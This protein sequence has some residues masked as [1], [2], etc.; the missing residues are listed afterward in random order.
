MILAAI[1]VVMSFIGTYGSAIVAVAS[2]AAA[3]LLRDSGGGPGGADQFQEGPRLGELGVTTSSYGKDIPIVRGTMRLAGNMFWAT[4]I[5]ERAITT[6]TDIDAG[7]GGGWFGKGGGSSSPHLTSVT[8]AYYGNFAISFAEGVAHRR[9]LIRVWADGKLIWDRRPGQQKSKKYDEMDIRMYPGSKTQ[10]PD[11]LIESDVGAANCPAYRDQCYVVIEN[12]P[13][14]DSGNRPPNFTAEISFNA[15]DSNPITDIGALTGVAAGAFWDRVHSALF[16]HDGTNIVRINMAE[17]AIETE[18]AISD[19]DD[20]YPGGWGLDE[21]MHATPE[22]NPVVRYNDHPRNY[23]RAFELEAHSLQTEDWDSR[24]NNWPTNTVAYDQTRVNKMHAVGMGRYIV[25]GCFNGMTILNL[26]ATGDGRLDFQDHAYM[27]NGANYYGAAIQTDRDGIVWCVGSQLAP[28]ANN[29]HL[30]K[31]E[32]VVS[33]PTNALLNFLE[34]FDLSSIH[35]TPVALAYDPATHSLIIASVLGFL[36]MKASVSRFDIETETILWTI[37]SDDVVLG[38]LVAGDGSKGMMK[39][40]TS[41]GYVYCMDSAA[42]VVYQIRI[43][44]GEVVSEI[45]L[46]DWGI[47]NTWGV[48]FYDASTHSIV[49]QALSAGPYLRHMV[50]LWLD[51][52]DTSG[53]PLEDVVADLA[54]RTGLQSSD[55]DLTQLVAAGDIVRGYMVTKQSTVR[56]ALEPLGYAYFFDAVESDHKVKFVK[57]GGASVVT[58]PEDDLGADSG[59]K[60]DRAERLVEEFSM[61]AELPNVAAIKFYNPD[62]DFQQGHEYA[63]RISNPQSM[64]TQGSE[65]TRTADLAMALMPAEALAIVETTLYQVWIGKR[66]YQFKTLPKHQL[67]EPADIVTVQNLSVEFLCRIMQNSLGAGYLCAFQAVSEDVES[68]TFSGLDTSGGDGF[69]GDELVVYGVSLPHLLD[70]P[71]LRDVDDPGLY[72]GILYVAFGASTDAW[73]GAILHRS[74]DGSVWEQVAASTHAAGWGTSVEPA[75]GGGMDDS[76]DPFYRWQ[77]WDRISQLRVR[78]VQGEDLL[79]SVSELDCLNG[80]NTALLGNEVIR[81]ANVS[82]PDVDGIYTLDTLIRGRRGTGQWAEAG[83]SRGS[84]LI[85]LSVSTIRRVSTPLSHINSVRF[86]RA[87]TLGSAMEDAAIYDL[88]YTAACLKPYAVADLRESRDGSNNISSTWKRRSRVSGDIDWNDAVAD[89]PIGETAEAYEV[90]YY[91]PEIYNTYMLGGTTTNVRKTNVFL[92][93]T[94]EE[95]LGMRVGI[96]HLDD[97]GTEE[98]SF[99]TNKVSDSEVNVDPP[100][101]KAPVLNTPFSVLTRE[102][103]Y[104]DESLVESAQFSAAEQTAAGIS[105]LGRPIWCVVY[106]MSS[107][108]GR[109]FPSM[110]W[111]W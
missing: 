53:V 23:D 11:S 76:L 70:T 38:G 111:A 75:G 33:V 62:K 105:P 4:E 90:D 97:Y 64:R 87:I 99:I 7:G 73:R 91:G 16:L 107:V 43:S 34:D 93:Y 74:E 58:I 67:I 29:C 100:W 41:G 2:I 96:R 26:D 94:E 101:S 15:A 25:S 45:D 12:M 37:T 32:I 18:R 35:H 56:S 30:Y 47:S 50:R 63:K 39:Y 55:L 24:E 57:R 72:A 88:T 110:I 84:R 20:Y 49:A 60:K 98:E 71:L 77:T 28:S 10:Q 6:V 68:Y 85:L 106:Q 81:F 83:H 65:E 95:L 109:G 46:D 21:G 80:A 54:T 102:P 108:V 82:G 31:V 5:E 3:F 42:Q 1:P 27:P 9:G 89:I 59:G 19:L 86:Y 69:K 61:E 40:G 51:R 103:A 92:N 17:N 79:T 104:T 36:G 13:L 48:P 66:A 14:A 78:M 22:G 44:D 52:A 8:Y